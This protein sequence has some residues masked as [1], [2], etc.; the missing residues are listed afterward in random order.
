MT[1]FDSEESTEAE[2]PIQVKHASVCLPYPLPPPL[3]PT[4]SL[5]D[6]Y[7][8]IRQLVNMSFQEVPSPHSDSER[9]SDSPT[10]YSDTPLTHTQVQKLKDG[11]NKTRRSLSVK[12][13]KNKNKV[14]LE[15]RKSDVQIQVWLRN[16]WIFQYLVAAM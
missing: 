4:P 14:K 13:V 11:S 2:H 6:F 12:E 8:S 5:S 1:R 3:P 7:Y 15:R 9:H 10:A 16:I